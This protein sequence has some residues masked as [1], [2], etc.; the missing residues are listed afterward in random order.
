MTQV[1]AITRY[2]TPDGRLTLEGLQL[3]RDLLAALAVL[4]AQIADHEARIAALEP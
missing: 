2:V 1:S 3:F 4:Q